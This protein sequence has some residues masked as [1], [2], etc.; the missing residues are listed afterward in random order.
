RFANL[1][2]ADTLR[3]GDDTR[4]SAGTDALEQILQLA[5][6]TV[7]ALDTECLWFSAFLVQF[8]RVSPPRAVVVR[9]RIL[10]NDRAGHIKTKPF[11]HRPTPLGAQRCAATDLV[12]HHD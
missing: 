9:S 6:V 5:N 7:F 8:E 11:G 12:P 2:C 10:E 3:R 4:R 1:N